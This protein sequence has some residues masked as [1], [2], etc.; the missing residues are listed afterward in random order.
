[1]GRIGG[2]GGVGMIV[3]PV[4]GGFAA[5]LGYTAP[6]YVAAAILL[7][8]TVWGLFAMP[9]SLQHHLRSSQLRLSEL[10]PL[11]QLTAIFHLARVRW[12]LLTGVLYYLPF[13]MFVTELAVLARDQLAW[14]PEQI[15]LGMLL[16]G[17]VD[18]VMQG[19]LSARL[20]PL[21][22]E[23]RLTAAGLVCEALAYV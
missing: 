5:L 16:I 14:G 12:L 6:L 8:N 1:F 3:G 23:V 13:A 15:G 11:V 9:E 22:G 17:C 20:M 7:L 21:F 10:N 19:V 18:I 2:I 4:I